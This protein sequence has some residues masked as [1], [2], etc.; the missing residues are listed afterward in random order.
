MAARWPSRGV[1]RVHRLTAIHAV[2]TSRRS[3]IVLDGLA[4]SYAEAF[5]RWSAVYTDAMS[6]KNINLSI[7]EDVIRAV[8]RHAAERG[9]TLDAIVREFLTEL[10]NRED[11]VRK[12]RQRIVELSN[13][14][15]ARI[16]SRVWTREEL[17]QR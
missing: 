12:A 9:S 16:G 10:A 13:R 14:S 11:R 3:I 7:D 5:W 8:R 2:D 15:T 4:G 17:H 1:E 6:M